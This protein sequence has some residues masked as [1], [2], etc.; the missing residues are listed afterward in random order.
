MQ[1]PGEP[2]VGDF[3]IVILVKQYVLWLQI[4]M[5]NVLGVYVLDTLEY[6]SH[7]GACLLL[8]ERH[9]RRQIVEEFALGAQLEY[10]K[11]KCIRLEHV[12]QV[13]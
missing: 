6:L 8:R 11:H 10:E 5:D 7:D 1:L 3:H 4:A 2:K 9:H 12:L 13:N